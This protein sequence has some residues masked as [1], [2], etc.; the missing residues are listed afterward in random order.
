MIRTITVSTL[1][2]GLFTILQS[3]IL[4]KIAIFGVIPDLALLVLVYIAV[5]NGSMEGQISGF[6]SGIV[7]DV[8][9][10]SFLGFSVLVKTVIGFLYGIIH[11]KLFIDALIGPFVL[12][13]TATVLKGA[14]Y[15][16]L[17]L[18]FPGSIPSFVLLGKV[19]W[20]EALYNAI[21]A[22][23]LFGLLNLVKRYLVTVRNRD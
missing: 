5:R 19:L 2:M 11:G 21:L 15:A 4:Q 1:L 7:V 3:T 12:A 16:F 23:F 14:L 13:F 17:G 22:P 8:V 9:S 20:L 10:G 6:L 18:I